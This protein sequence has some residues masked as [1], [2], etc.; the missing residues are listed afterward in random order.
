MRRLVIGDLSRWGLTPPEEGLFARLARDTKVPAIVDK[1]VIEAIKAGRIEIV[2]GVESLDEHAVQLAD[3]G[4]VEPDVIICAT[5]YRPG[6][7]PLVGH[8]GVL[9]ERGLPRS[10]GERAAMAGLRFVGYVPRPGGLGYISKEANRAARAIVREL[11]SSKAQAHPRRE[12]VAAG[13]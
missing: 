4:E 5:G 10:L 8:L 7:E 11:R 1:E 12:P 6:L 9:D 3:G 13:G 2:R